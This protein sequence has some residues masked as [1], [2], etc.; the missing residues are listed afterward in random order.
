MGI[1]VL[2][3][4]YKKIDIR[5]LIKK[6][7]KKVVEEIIETI[8]SNP[9]GKPIVVQI[10]SNRKGEGKTHIIDS[11]A[12]Q[13][14]GL[15][16]KTLIV[17]MNGTSSTSE[18]KV[19]VPTKETL[20]AKSYL[21]IV[22]DASKY[23]VVLVEIPALFNTILNTTLYQTANLSYLVADAGRIWTDADEVM[24]EKLKNDARLHLKGIL[25]KVQPDNMDDFLDE[26]P[27]KRSRLRRFIKYKLLRK[28]L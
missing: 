15:G 22:P 4:K 16:I 12:S 27:K 8:H 3:K 6:G 13:L 1:D 9:A 2:N 18:D 19:V 26:I 25:N 10:F 20:T 7:L 17:E 24:T 28:L 21:E 11:L 23:E 14:K 5:S